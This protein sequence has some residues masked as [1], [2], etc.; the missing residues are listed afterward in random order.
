[1]NEFTTLLPV[2]SHSTFNGLMSYKHLN[3]GSSG[4]STLENRQAM[5][6]FLSGIERRA[7]RMAEIATSSSDEALDLVQDAMMGLV[8]RYSDKPEAEWGPLFH[9][10]LQSR[11]RDWYRRATVRNKVR[12][13]LHLSHKDDEEHHDPIQSAPDQQGKDPEKTAWN[14]N[15]GDAI[16]QALKDLPLRQQQAFLLRNWEGMSVIET[17]KAMG[18]SQGSVKTHYS[19]AVHSMRNALEDHWP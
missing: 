9:R 1:M 2:N 7:F 6:Q 12:G 17:A 14:D 4:E 10:I 13:W 11:I 19:R 5:N 15:A 16:N 18:C 3:N 8:Q